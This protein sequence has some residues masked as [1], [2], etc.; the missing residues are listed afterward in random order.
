M[1][2]TA[3]R[4]ALCPLSGIQTVR[5]PRGGWRRD[6]PETGGDGSSG[7][8][9]A[10]SGGSNDD[11]TGG[12]T[13]KAGDKTPTIQGDLDPD[14]AAA[15]IASAREAEKKAKADAKADRDRLAAVLKA[16]GLTPDGKADPEQQVRELT[17]R[18]SAAEKKAAALAEREAVRDAASTHGA[19]AGELLDSQKFLD[20]LKELDPT[21]SDY[22]DKVAG[23][24]KKAV[25]DNPGKY[26]TA[27]PPATRS[28]A[29]DHTGG[30]GGSGERPRSIRE[31]FARANQ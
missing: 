14:R 20:Q 1:Y 5:P 13:G 4:V 30:S 25:K 21:A 9:N 2:R 12:D 24:V 19:N 17:E 7:H 11:T 18:A 15:A 22:S 3:R 16:A 27:K 28:G 10:G 26:G 29:G 31:A 6:D 8:T 23:L